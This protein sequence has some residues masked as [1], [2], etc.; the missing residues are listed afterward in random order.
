MNE[1]RKAA[2]PSSGRL[3]RLLSLASL[4]AVHLVVLILGGDSRREA[5]RRLRP[6]GW[7]NGLLLGAVMR[8]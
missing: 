4:A 7:I 5:A 8:S 1:H 6:L 2:R 3:T